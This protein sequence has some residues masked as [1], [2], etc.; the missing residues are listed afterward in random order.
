VQFLPPPDEEGADAAAVQK[1]DVAAALPTL[2][3]EEAL[4]Y[5]NPRESGRD[6]SPFRIRGE[7]VR[8]SVRALI[9]VISRILS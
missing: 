5:E 8:M 9:L 6:P 2:K 3:V 1:L 7:A 4:Q